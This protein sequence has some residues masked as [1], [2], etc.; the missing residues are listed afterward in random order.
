LEYYNRKITL[1]YRFLN[2]VVLQLCQS[3]LIRQMNITSL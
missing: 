2:K 3:L 1:I